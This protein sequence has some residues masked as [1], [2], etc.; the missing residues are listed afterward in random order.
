M[1][2]NLALDLLISAGGVALIVLI[3]VLL[4]AWKTVRLDEAS[5]RGRLELDEPDFQPSDLLVGADGKA[6]LAIGA[7][8]DAALVFALGDGLATRRFKPGDY[9]VKAAGA[10]VELNLRDPSKWRVRLAAGSPEAAA[11]WAGRL[12][13]RAI[14]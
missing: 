9:Q 4:G 13:G 14:P 11:G 3:S 1:T 2:G 10:D 12:S 8:G 6:A 7:N 5:A